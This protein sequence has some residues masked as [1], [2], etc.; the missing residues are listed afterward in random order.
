[1]RNVRLSTDH[2]FSVFQH[3]THTIV[4]LDAAWPWAS[5]AYGLCRLCA[6]FCAH[7]LVRARSHGLIILQVVASSMLQS[8]QWRWILLGLGP[9]TLM[10]FAVSA[11]TFV[12][13][14]L[15]VQDHTLLFPK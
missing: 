10:G 7:K 8:Q 9:M 3:A 6:Y 11:H 12:R 5:E 13:I 4:V 2:C 15:Y 1:M 14:N